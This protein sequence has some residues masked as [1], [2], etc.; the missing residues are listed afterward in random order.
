[1]LVTMSSPLNVYEM[2]QRW[3]LL[4]V[5]FFQKEENM[6]S[7]LTYLKSKCLLLQKGTE[8]SLRGYHSFIILNEKET[9]LEKKI[10]NPLLKV[11]FT[12]PQ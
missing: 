5:P 7:M 9:T 11:H 2:R 3:F 8:Q 6:S 4:E 12:F 10:N 1:M